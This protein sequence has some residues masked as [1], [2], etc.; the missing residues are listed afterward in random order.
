MK[1]NARMQSFFPNANQKVI[2][3]AHNRV[4]LSTGHSQPRGNGGLRGGGGGGQGMWSA[5]ATAAA[6]IGALGLQTLV[7]ACCAPAPIIHPLIHAPCRHGLN[8]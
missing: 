1:V 7:Q 3:K 8:L 6:G 5:A 2:L 4:C